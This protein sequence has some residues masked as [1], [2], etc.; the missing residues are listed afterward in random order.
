MKKKFILII[1]MLLVL[2]C[3][4]AISVSAETDPNANYYDKVYVDLN[5]REFPIYEKAGDTYYPLV[6]FAYDVM[7]TDELSGET[8]VVETKYVKA[9]FEDCD[10]YSAEPSQGRFNGIRY[11]YTDENGNEM[12]LDTSN[13]VV[14]NMRSGKMT[15]A[16]KSN[17]TVAG[18][19][20]TIKT[21]ET[22]KSGYPWIDRLEAI[23]FPLTQTAVGGITSSKIRVADIDRNHPISIGI[24]HK[25]FESSGITE[26]F[27]PGNATIGGNSTFQGCTKLEKVVF[28]SGF[29][30]DLPN[31][32]F[33]RC[34]SLK[35]VC[36]MDGEDA[37][38]NIQVGTANNGYYTNLIRISYEDYSALSDKSGKYLV[39]SASPCL[40]FYGDE[41]TASDDTRL[42]GNDY[43]AQIKIACPCAI[44]GCIATI[45]TGTIDPIFASKGYSASTFGETLS[46]T[47]GFYINQAALAEYMSYAESVE[48]GVVAA[49]NTTEGA[50]AP[51]FESPKTIVAKLDK[52]ATSYVDVKVVGISSNDVD[53]V[54]AFCMYISVDGK[55]SFLDGGV[56][57]NTVVGKSYSSII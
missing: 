47:Q 12:V 49:V 30:A 5:G 28:G 1:S 52:I 2:V 16:I 44:D 50:F 22:Y 53:T 26:I 27:I 45:Q 17:G 41:H 46:V 48:I 31:Y 55:V 36:F 25:A 39:Y 23:Y 51:D 3:A 11:S 14:I 56:T 43:F 20:I 4:L 8:V 33:D 13:A 21:I 9:H 10:V 38:D 7:G 37:L 19:N 40:A 29:S 15:R 35:M 42:I 6:W 34:S 24:G 57:G 18:T 32:F 54:I